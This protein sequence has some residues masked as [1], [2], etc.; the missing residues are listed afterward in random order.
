MNRLHS[1]IF[2]HCLH[3]TLELPDFAS[4]PA[5]HAESIVKST[6]RGEGIS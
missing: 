1:V 4:S 3:S 2:P 6:W 5:A